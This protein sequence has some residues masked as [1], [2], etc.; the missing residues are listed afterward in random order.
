M[1]SKLSLSHIFFDVLFSDKGTQQDFFLSLTHSEVLMTLSS[2]TDAM[3][4]AA[5]VFPELSL[6]DCKGGRRGRQ[7][8]DNDTKQKY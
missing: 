3:S 5:L 7:N 2:R 4:I 6:L 8:L 1:M